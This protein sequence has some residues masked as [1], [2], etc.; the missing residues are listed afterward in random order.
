MSQLQGFFNKPLD[1][2]HSNGVISYCNWCFEAFNTEGR[3]RTA[4]LLIHNQAF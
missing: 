4:D 2:G 1:L 3:T